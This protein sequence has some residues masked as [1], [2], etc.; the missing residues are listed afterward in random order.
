MQILLISR[1]HNVQDVRSK[2]DVEMDCVGLDD[3]QLS[4]F[5]FREM[6]GTDSVALMISSKQNGD[7]EYVPR[8]SKR[9]YSVV[10]ME[11]KRTALFDSLV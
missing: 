5:F 2:V 1:S 10:V 11:G 7:L 6:T 3:K 4:G 8:F 9:E